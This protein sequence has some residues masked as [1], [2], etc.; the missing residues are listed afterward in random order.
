MKLTE[1]LEKENIWCKD[2]IKGE[3]GFVSQVMPRD[4]EVVVKDAVSS[5]FFVDEK[6][7]K[8][9][10]QEDFCFALNHS[11]N[12]NIPDKGEEIIGN[13]QGRNVYR[14]LCRKTTYVNDKKNGLMTLIGR[15]GQI[16]SITMFADDKENGDEVWYN[17]DGK[18]QSM[19]TNKDGVPDGYEI[20]CDDNGTPR[21]YVLWKKGE[22]ERMGKVDES[23]ISEIV[24][25]TE[26]RTAALEKEAGLPQGIS[27]GNRLTKS[28]G[29]GQ[30]KR[31]G[32]TN[33]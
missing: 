20:L 10:V 22:R 4:A 5:R 1:K 27:L 6:G 11:L 28:I 30:V 23:S 13:F 15:N 12:A 24:K 17:H 7:K 14:S 9:G 33:G 18:R 2:G 16:L 3:I 29:V 19:R 26:K 25:A 31:G 8:Q 32:Y 21:G